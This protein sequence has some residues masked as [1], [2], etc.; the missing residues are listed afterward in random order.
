MEDKEYHISVRGEKLGPLTTDEVQRKIAAGEVTLNDM[1]WKAGLPDWVPLRVLMPPALPPSAATSSPPPLPKNIPGMPIVYPVLSPPKKKSMTWLW[2]TLS[3]VLVLAFVGVIAGSVFLV[4]RVTKLGTDE[5]A[6]RPLL[7]ERAK[8]QPQWRES[9]YTPSGPADVPDGKV[10]ELIRYHSEGRDLAA[11]LTPDP[12]DGKKHPAIVW[13]HGGFGGI[14]RY[15][16]E[17]VSKRNDQSARAFREKGIVMMCPSWRGE[18]DN[19]GRFELFYGEVEDFLWA[20]QHVKKLPYVDPERVYIGGHSTG[21]TMTLLAA[22]SSDQFRAAFSFGGMIDGVA[23]LGDGEGYGNTPYDPASNID[24]RLRS[25]TRYAKFMRRPT[26]YFEGGEYYDGISAWAM[27][28]DAHGHLQT[29]Q[30]P[31]DHF[32]IL[33]PI[34]PLIAEKILQDKGPKCNIRF[35]EAELKQRYEAAF[36]HTLATELAAWSRSGGSLVERLEKADEDDML[37]H[38]E[39]DLKAVVQAVKQAKTQSP[40]AT[41]NFATLADLRNGIEDEDLLA[42]FDK[43]A[44]PALIIWAQGR[45]NEAAAFEKEEAETFFNLLSALAGARNADAADLVIAAVRSGKLP[46]TH[47]WGSVFNAYDDEHPHTEE[48]MRAF[49]V[50]PPPNLVGVLL[51]DAANNLFLDGW[52]GTHPF[53]SVKG[54]ALMKAWLEHPDPE[55]SGHAHSAALGAAFVKAVPR[56]ELI[57]LALEHAD[58]AVQMEG[59]WSDVKAEDG[60]Q[61][62]AFL[63][64]SCLH[65]HQSARAQDYLKELNREKDIPQQALEPAFAAQA[66]ISQWLQH[67]S[68]LGN[69]PLS[70][71]VYDHQKLFW[72]PTKDQREMWL[73]KFTHKDGDKIKTSYGCVGSMTWSS[74]EE[75]STPPPPAELYLH[76]CTL[77]LERDQHRTEGAAKKDDARTQALEA[78]K[79]G[80]PGVFDQ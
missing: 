60:K 38:T 77:E 24:H 30:L 3:I 71:E 66:K 45:L 27:K 58:K 39:A 72:P 29:Y 21:G 14:G 8:H 55:Q 6:F 20:I 41:A 4:N 64:Q 2:V 49:A 74:F 34:T 28:L 43:Q 16:W 11:Y 35:T 19:A 17:P 18:N 42:G 22:V 44:V 46:D 12:K 36:S 78:L 10:F 9:D 51:L 5:V 63:Q 65:L 50:D 23:T 26:F 62:L 68:E 59:A 73:I 1:A 80:N 54:A 37:L 15:F 79:K 53:D 47:H 25:P 32:D 57:A 13:A 67:P 33:H 7:E 69:E 48:I 75:F 31:G 61:G 52:E 70:I 76:H 40:E 56:D